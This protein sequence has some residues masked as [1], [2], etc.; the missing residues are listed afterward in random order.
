MTDSVNPTSIPE[1]GRSVFVCSKPIQILNCVS[2]IRRY[3]IDRP[4]L[5][6]HSS[7]VAEVREFR[8]FFEKSPYS[9][10]FE[11]V[12]WTEHA[13]DAALELAKHEFDSLFIH[14]DRVSYYQLFAPLKSQWL[15]LYEEGLGTYRGQYA[16]T[17]NLAKRMKWKVIS[18]FTGCGFE[19][20]SGRKTDFVMV[21]NPGVFQRFNSKT[22]HKALSFPGLVSEIHEEA[23]TWKQ[24]AKN[25]L[26]DREIHSGQVCLVLGTWGGSPGLNGRELAQSYDQV[27]FKSHP[28]DGSGFIEDA[29]QAANSWVPAEVLI[30]YLATRCA[31]LDVLHYSSS[32]AFYMKEIR[33]NVFFKDL[34]RSPQLVEILES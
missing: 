13:S 27:F 6:V 19:F 12:S 20:G 14:D 32:A 33:E 30:D 8:D 17:M 16:V 7:G 15:V 24:V 2:I 23:E 1:F 22:G 11:F 26:A 4:L 10:H 3:G 5:F 28:H 29:I 18:L 31:R 34:R 9:S 21:A 25:A